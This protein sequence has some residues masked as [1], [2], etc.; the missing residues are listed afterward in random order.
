M[1]E[2]RGLGV[3]YPTRGVALGGLNLSVAPGEILLLA[4]RV[5]AGAS[6]A[7]GAICARLPAG[8]RRQG[9]I[10]VGGVDVSA[11][12]P[13]DL[14]GV[15][16]ML[17][18]A[19]PGPSLRIR[20]LLGGS[21]RR[22]GSGPSPLTP[23]E[24]VERLGLAHHLNERLAEA[25]ASLRARATL[26][27]VLLGAPRVLLADQPLAAL[28]SAWRDE[29]CAVL[30]EHAD[31]GMSILW[32]EHHLVHALAVADSVIELQRPDAQP[33]TK[34][35]AQPEAQ[36]A[37]SWRPRTLPFTPLQQVASALGLVA[38]GA[39]TSQG[40]G[41]GL[42]GR[43]TGARRNV[44]E[45]RDSGLSSLRLSADETIL[46]GDGEPVRI[47]CASAT[48]STALYR[49]IA[50]AN[51]FRAAPLS[52]ND[53]LAEICAGH[54]RAMGR[55]RDTTA[56]RLAR[57]AGQLRLHDT[58][59]RHSRGE[60]ALIAALLDLERGAVVPLLEVGRD[61]DGHSRA[62]L[63][64]AILGELTQGRAVLEISTDVEELAS[65]RRV[66]VHDGA[67][68]VADGRPM[69]IV[70][71]LPYLP[72]LAAAC[73]PMRLVTPDEVITAAQ[74]GAGLGGAP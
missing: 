57:L 23:A 35:R 65:A 44:P 16:T 10:L 28:E 1:L 56:A 66:L 55:V 72:R 2:V 38:P 8:A 26:V 52:P 14:R 46:A 11:A 24:L 47:V 6:T 69:A 71:N 32:A 7:L 49:R 5:G 59:A 22:P 63:D 67:R 3:W 31:A 19:D 37:W 64:E 58:L 9:R 54:D 61:L 25:S 48:V 21:A 43:L 40:L 45:R 50:A 13:D 34:P 42:A 70:D 39:D 29:A 30:R 68:V 4:G 53:T 33:G 60:Q 36:P 74:G 51:G 20:E 41:A 27:A 62:L 73:A 15:L 18:D 17:G 12:H